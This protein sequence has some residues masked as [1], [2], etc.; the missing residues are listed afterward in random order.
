M[1]AVRAGELM[2]TRA[3]VHADATFAKYEESGAYHWREIG[4]GLISHNAFTAERYRQVDPNPLA[5]QLAGA[6]LRSH[7]VQATIHGST[8]SLPPDYYDRVI[9]TEVIEHATTPGNLLL[10]FAR[11]LKPGGRLVVTTPIRLTEVP[12]DPNHVHEWFPGEFARLFETG[13]WRVIAHEQVVP[14]AAPEVYFWRP[15]IFARIPVFRL[16]CNLLSIGAGVNAMSWLR[17][18]PR[19]FMMQIVIAEKG[20]R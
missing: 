4:W 2:T 8:A 17:M 9:C 19:L 1:G 15:I 3:G 18:R 14:A 7:G 12:E 20:A 11:V 13:I 5:V 16:L 6:M 10:D